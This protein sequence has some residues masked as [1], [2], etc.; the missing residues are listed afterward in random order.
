MRLCV[1]AELPAVSVAR[2]FALVI[3][4][5]ALAFGAAAPAICAKPNPTACQ[6]SGLIGEHI[7]TPQPWRWLGECP[8]GR[9]EGL[10]VLRMGTAESGYTFFY[11]RMHGG[12][13]VAGYLQR[14]LW[15]RLA[16]GF[17]PAGLPIEPDVRNNMDQRHAVF[18]LGSRAAMATSRWFA[19]RGNR[20]SARWY[21]ERARDILD[22]EPR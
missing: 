3:A 22:V 11:G 21:R 19:A 4:P 15:V 9:A 14:D 6:A 17:T 16:Y 1:V 10:G 18:V 20:A 2:T 8:N 13:P 5:A 7:P 12:R